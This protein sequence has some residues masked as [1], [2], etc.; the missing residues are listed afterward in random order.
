MENKAFVVTPDIFEKVLKKFLD[1]LKEKDIVESYTVNHNERVAVVGFNKDAK[2]PESR[3]DI[4][5]K[6]LFRNAPTILKD[7]GYEDIETK[8][9]MLPMFSTQEENERVVIN[10]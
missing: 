3:E 8:T 1:V 9:E 7:L 2:I 10:Y 5:T 6:G 4:I